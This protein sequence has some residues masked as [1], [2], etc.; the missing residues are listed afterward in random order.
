MPTI[1]QR[2]QQHG[3]TI[4][5]EINALAQ[6]HDTINLGQGRPDFDGP[7]EIIEATVEA[8]RSGLANQYPPGLGISDLR[9]AIS[10][11]AQ[12]R[13]GLSV[14]PDDGI[15]VTC[16]A[17]EGIFSA[18]MG[19]VNPGDEVILIEPYFDIY[20]PAI[21]WA[22]GIPVYVPMYPPE[23]RYDPEELRS[24]F[25]PRTRAIILNTPH[26]PTGRVLK[27]DELQ[28]IAELC[29]EHDVIAISDE[30]YE[31]LT[32]EEAKHIPIATLP[33]MAERTLTISSAAKTYSFTG[34]KVG[35][36]MGD[37]SLITGAWRIH[38]NVTFAIN[39]PA[40]VGITHALRMP[41]DYYTNLRHD[42]AQKREHLLATLQSSGFKSFAPE[43]AF[44][45]MADF[46]G[47]HDG[48]ANDFTRF[49]ITEIG[50][51]CI[52][53]ATFFSPEHR[54]LARQWVRFAFCKRD[55]VLQSASDRLTR[56]Q[57]L[58]RPA[59]DR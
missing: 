37:P 12:R 14:N 2:V 59:H 7:T 58:R 48:D 6:Q 51:A 52:P 9:Q 38:Q 27:R 19:I 3:T 17:S 36:V 15:I 39:H 18:I 40:Q 31:H 13:Y 4:F 26:N 34:W 32:Y 33:G 49:L 1:A 23:W 22:G 21:E 25:G 47:L 57:E 8:L 45:I 42:Y 24:A 41:E 11:H 10:A 50:V 55:D 20:L 56:L 28:L 46:T 29:Q 16:G 44:Y 54:H 53:P 35:W 5:S 30:V 43:G